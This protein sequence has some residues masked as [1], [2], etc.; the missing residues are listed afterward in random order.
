MSII[1]C[2]QNCIHQSEG[3]CCLNEISALTGDCG[4][5]KCG[6]FEPRQTLPG[7]SHL[8]FHHPKGISKAADPNKL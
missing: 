1:P 5:G 4:G 2:S 6:Y 3:Y 8:L 7:Q